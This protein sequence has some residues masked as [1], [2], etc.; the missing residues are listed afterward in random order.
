MI[1]GYGSFHTYYTAHTVCARE[2]PHFGVP[3]SWMKLGK[4]STTVHF[5]CGYHGITLHKN[6]SYTITDTLDSNFH[7]Y[8]VINRF[9]LISTRLRRD[10]Y[11]LCQKLAN[12]RHNLG[13]KPE[14]DQTMCDAHNSRVFHLVYQR[15]GQFSCNSIILSYAEITPFV[16]FVFDHKT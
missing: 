11:V 4:R 9:L 13:V 8:L 10:V 3:P 12:K 2:T 6:Q 5:R 16:R 14:I 1:W 15:R 7:P